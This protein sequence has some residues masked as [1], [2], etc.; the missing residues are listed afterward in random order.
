ML[1]T[2]GEKIFDLANL[3]AA[4][5]I[6]GKV[7]DPTKV[8]NAALWLGG[9]IWLALYIFGVIFVYFGGDE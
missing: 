8:P 9:I 3:A 6:F 4:V 2:I 7:L 1:K 5:L